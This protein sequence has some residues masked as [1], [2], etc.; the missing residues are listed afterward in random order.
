[1]RIDLHCHTTFS[2]QGRVAQQP[3]DSVIEIEEIPLIAKEQGLDGVVITDHMTLEAGGHLVE[4]TKRKHLDFLL[5]RGMEYHSDQGHLLIY[6]ISDDSVCHRFGKYGPIQEVINYVNSVGGCVV[7]SHPFI[8]GYTH[9]LQEKVFTLNG[10]TALEV[11]NGQ[12]DERTNQKA[13]QAAKKL[14]LPGTGG[15]DSHHPSAIGSVYTVFPNK[16]TSLAELIT[17]LK[18]GNYRAETKSS[19]Y[20]A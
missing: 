9:C 20:P 13:A 18:S 10:L 4:Q 17:Q 14:G 16:I 2:Y 19:S 8:S 11:I 7:P 12:L 5:L 6:G 15:S 3:S 1:M